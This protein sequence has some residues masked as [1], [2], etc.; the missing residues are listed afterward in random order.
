MTGTPYLTKSPILF[1]IFNR[2][3]TTYKVFEKIREAKPTRLYIAADGPR[4]DR[5]EEESLCTETRAVS[6][7]VDWDCDVKILFRNHNLGCKN[8]VSS[9]LDWFFSQEDDGIILEDDCLPANDFFFFCDELLEKYRFDTRI[10]HIG[11]SNLQYGN[12]RGD[13]SYYFANMTHVWGWASWKRA[14]IDYDKN[15]MKYE[16]KDVAIQLGK[17]FSD[18]LIVETWTEIFRMVKE[19]EIDTWDYQLGFI[20]FFNNGL[21]IIP[22]TNLI[23]NIG[24]REDATHTLSPDNPN[25]NIPLGELKA[26]V[27]PVYFLPEKEADVYTLNH[28][29]NIEERRAQEKEEARLVEKNK[30][31]LRNRVKQ[32]FKH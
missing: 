32:F 5:I 9:A 12:T 18:P 29:F 27:H 20:N 24:F 22:N 30:R 16:Q 19:G 15:L 31:K 28:D 26:L 14:W 13:A 4:K 6:K 11:G 23:S 25:A 10:R 21:T 3:D 2:P 8:A 1:L 7:L 17:I